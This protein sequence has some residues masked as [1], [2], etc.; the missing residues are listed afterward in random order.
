MTDKKRNEADRRAN[1]R[2]EREEA[3]ERK[4][5]E[6]ASMHVSGEEVTREG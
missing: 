2:K 1:E 4:E 5:R 6:E 3:N